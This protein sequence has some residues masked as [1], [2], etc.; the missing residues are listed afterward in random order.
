MDAEQIAVVA[1]SYHETR[2][3][4][5]EL[6]RQAKVLEAKE[7]LILAQFPR[8]LK[9]GSYD[10][11]VVGVDRT[12]VPKVDN[13]PEFH[14][15][16]IATGNLDMLQKRLTPNAVMARINEGEIVPGVSTDEKT[17]YKVEQD[18]NV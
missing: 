2:N 11:W 3:K 10:G 14:Q 15:Y 16:L 18:V 4:R 8:D 9:A 1:K 12:T 5:L 13:W 6:E 7:K 17:S